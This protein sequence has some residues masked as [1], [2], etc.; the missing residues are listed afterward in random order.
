MAKYDVGFGKPPES[1]R[2]RRGQSGNPKGRP[3]RKTSTYA[4]R[5]VDLLDAPV[6]YRE[7]GKTKVATRRELAIKM[8]IDKAV[9]GGHKEIKQV[10]RMLLRAMR[11]PN[12][13]AV[14]IVV[15]NWLPDHSGQTAEQKGADVDARKTFSSAE[16]TGEDEG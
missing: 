15:E 1:G 16:R 2:F 10:L 6:A 4:E 7:A 8:L 11:N 9:N 12:V 3:K 5:V 13:G 14:P